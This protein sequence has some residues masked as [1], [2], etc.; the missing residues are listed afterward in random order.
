MSNREKL[1]SLELK[2][3]KK[4]SLERERERHTAKDSKYHPYW[5]INFDNTLRYVFSHASTDENES[6]FFSVSM[7][8]FLVIQGELVSLSVLFHFRVIRCA[9]TFGLYDLWDRSD[10]PTAWS[11]APTCGCT[12][13]YDKSW[14]IWA[15][16]AHCHTGCHSKQAERPGQ[17]FAVSLR[18]R[19]PL[20]YSDRWFCNDS[21]CFLLTDAS[22]C[23]NCAMK[24]RSRLEPVSYLIEEIQ[25]NYV[26]FDTNKC[27]I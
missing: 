9:H 27:I 19:V 14:R 3:T 6:S 1:D 8:L 11:D 16:N 4:T 5:R 21:C 10:P 13:E 23:F 12:R 26:W 2:Y 20:V 25:H 7:A 17:T 18:C 15:R 22:S 24:D